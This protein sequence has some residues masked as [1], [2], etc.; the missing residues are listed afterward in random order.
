MKLRLAENFRAAFYAPFYATQALGCFAREGLEVE[1]VASAKPGDAIAGLIDGT[2]DLT[3][4]GPMR[5]MQAREQDP[6][7][8]LVCFAEVVARD[9]FYLIGRSDIVDFRLAD[10][11]H[12][13]VATVAEVPT[14][15]TCLQHDL[16]LA[17]LDPALV[18]R[19]AG[20]T[21]AQNVAA[22]RDGDLDV[23]QAFEPFVAAAVS[24]GF[25]K[26]LYAAS[27]RGPCVYTSFIASRA[28]IAQAPEAFAAIVR[29]VAAMQAWLAT[30]EANALAAAVAAYFPDV[31]PALLAA[32]LSRYRTAGIWAATPAMS[33]EG[34][35][36]LAESFQSGGLLLRMPRFEDCVEAGLG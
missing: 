23:V 21:M 19:V 35:V 9:P 17:G 36:R 32:A 33:R 31:A 27:A 2:I 18:A 12:L 26:I 6:K 3:W 29:A 8:P 24:E 16:R 10:L 25:A 5:V 30:H 22:L 1:L 20:R 13:R 7:S 34:F 14:P 11:A 15:W 4:G 28:R